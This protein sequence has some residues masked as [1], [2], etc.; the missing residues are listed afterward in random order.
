M[1]VLYPQLF[2]GFG[3]LRAAVAHGVSAS[4]WS[5]DEV[6]A[7]LDN[8][9]GMRL[10]IYDPFVDL[11][12]RPV[13]A[14]VAFVVIA[15]QLLV[16]LALLLN[17]RPVEWT[18]IGIFLN[19]HFIMGGAVNPSVFYVV[20]GLA[21]VLSILWDRNTPE[22]AYRIAVR[23]TMLAAAAV[24][25]CGPFTTTLDPAHVIEDPS[26]ILITLSSLFAVSCWM[27]YSELA[28]DGTGRPVGRT[29]A[30]VLLPPTNPSASDEPTA[31]TV[32]PRNR[33]GVTGAR[34]GGHAGSSLET[35]LQE[36]RAASPAEIMEA[37]DRPI[38]RLPSKETMSYHEDVDSGFSIR[39]LPVDPGDEVEAPTQTDPLVKGGPKKPRSIAN[40]EVS[41]E[42]APLNWYS[43]RCHF[44]VDDRHYE[45]R[46][47]VW[48]AVGFDDAIDLAE[49]E[50]DAYA[51]KIDG[52]YLGS[53]DCFHLPDTGMRASQGAEMYSLVR[54]S[55][56]DP[57]TYLRTFF[58]TGSERSA[59]V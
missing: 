20:M 21:V 11:F 30:A 8:N 54:A 55:D 29:T 1:S 59:E 38:R 17:V 14:V 28:E 47:T 39:E 42:K 46:I 51:S 40:F 53:C 18:L 41:T 6:V 9:A 2:L 32:P 58:F 5:G 35:D 33:S 50:A 52:E 12:V 31:R 13:P 10:P 36:L 45:E 25:I 27:M 3:W 15:L 44:R 26:L 23:S 4:W 56:L 49:S 37:M 16:G 43:V 48:Q 22:K 57:D 24:V 34:R 7:F 19:V